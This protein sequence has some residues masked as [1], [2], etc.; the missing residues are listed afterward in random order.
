MLHRIRLTVVLVGLLPLF[1]AFARHAGA[2]HDRPA[3]TVVRI[4]L[5]N[6]RFH[7]MP[8]QFWSNTGFC[9]PA[10]TNDATALAAFFNGRAVR[11]QLDLMSALPATGPDRIAVRVHWLLNLIRAK[12]VVVDVV[13]GGASTTIQYDFTALDTFVEHLQRSDNLLPVWEW[14]GDPSGVFSSAH[15]QANGS[16]RRIEEDWRELVV[17]LLSRYIGECCMFDVM[18]ERPSARSS[19]NTHFYPILI[20]VRNNEQ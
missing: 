14:M 4:S 9:P 15:Q 12:R 6:T 13:A 20:C 2:Q 18:N 16:Q 11:L 7:R 10:P 17:E 19:K 5:S 1:I 3:D 8:A